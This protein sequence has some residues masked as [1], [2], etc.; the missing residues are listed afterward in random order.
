MS[1]ESHHFRQIFEKHAGKS[2]LSLKICDARNTTCILPKQRYSKHMILTFIKVHVRSGVAWK[3]FNSS[4]SH[5]P[6]RSNCNEVIWRAA[7]IRVALAA[8]GLSGLL[9][10]RC[11]L[12]TQCTL[13]PITTPSCGLRPLAEGK[14]HIQRHVEPQVRCKLASDSI[15]DSF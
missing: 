12:Y 5:S 1:L 2:R 11:C 8:L 15:I 3:I 13:F 4:F 10:Y 7:G 9:C 6:P 14:P